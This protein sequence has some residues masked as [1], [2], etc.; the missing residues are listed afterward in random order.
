LDE[1]HRTDIAVQQ[2]LILK[3]A[4]GTA[5]FADTIGIFALQESKI[6]IPAQTTPLNGKGAQED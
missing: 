4:R 3:S 1:E 6:H 5:V 2:R